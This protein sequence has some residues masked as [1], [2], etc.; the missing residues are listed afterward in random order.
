MAKTSLWDWTRRSWRSVVA[1][2]AGGKTGSTVAEACRRLTMQALDGDDMPSLLRK[3]CRELRACSGA[4]GTAVLLRDE[5]SAGARCRVAAVDGWPDALVG[6]EVDPPRRDAAASGESSVGKAP[7]VTEATGLA[8]FLDPGAGLWQPIDDEGQG[9]GWIAVHMRGSEPVDRDAE[10]GASAL[11]AI[12]G[13]ALRRQRKLDHLEAQVARAR[14]LCDSLP[15][16]WICIDMC[17]A[18]LVDCHPSIGVWLGFGAVDCIGRPMQEFVEAGAAAEVDDAL[19]RAARD[20][21][22]SGVPMRLRHRNGRLLEFVA[23]AARLVDAGVDAT[24]RVVFVLHDRPA[25]GQASDRSD[26][27]EFDWTL[28]A[29]RERRE[30]ALGWLDG[31]REPLL[32]LQAQLGHDGALDRER[33]AA[34]LA[35]ARRATED[36]AAA[37]AV[38]DERPIELFA[39]LA[40]LI[41]GLSL[42]HSLTCSLDVDA[43]DLRLDERTKLALYRASR[44]LLRHWAAESV[45]REIE[46]RVD[47]P[48]KGWARVRFSRS[49]RAAGGGRSPRQEPLPP[50]RGLGIF[51]VKTLLAGVGGSLRIGADLG[52]G[53][54]AEIVVPEA[55]GLPAGRDLPADMRK[56]AAG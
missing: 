20:G 24:A 32:A 14:A 41:R 1:P 48:A 2:L 3:V 10:A 18:T 13:C 21:V 7:P 25:Q 6:S 28:E 40:E 34:L 11:A 29:V 9:R 22:A 33:C 4:A 39:A 46:V 17:D 53:R 27:R 51:G 47:A 31:L 15:V 8:P 38:P 23:D 5:A 36:A 50:A 44:D 37:L 16:P 56:A 45:E 12:V 49:P 30:K 54:L 19:R 42:R 55:A 35:R 52:P 43:R 26:Q